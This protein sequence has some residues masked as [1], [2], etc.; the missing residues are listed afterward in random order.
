M[1]IWMQKRMFLVHPYELMMKRLT[2]SEDSSSLAPSQDRAPT[3]KLVS[4][5]EAASYLGVS[6][7]TISNYI[8]NGEIQVITIGGRSRIP[9]ESLNSLLKTN[10]YKAPVS[11]D[12]KEYTT[13]YKMADEYHRSYN[14]VRAICREQGLKPVV[15][16]TIL[17]M[18][19]Q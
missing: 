5:A 16:S 9:K 3:K 17:L 1:A 14:F 12:F 6:K 15:R 13:F 7:R 2:E 4:I 18:A 8:S 10:T 19:N 11:I